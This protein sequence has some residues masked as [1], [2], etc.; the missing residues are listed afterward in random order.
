MT[1]GPKWLIWMGSLFWMVT[2]LGPENVNPR[3]PFNEMLGCW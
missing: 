1:D 3:D 2:F